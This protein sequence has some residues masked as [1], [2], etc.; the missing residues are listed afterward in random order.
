MLKLNA[1]YQ[2]K[3][4]AEQEYSSKCFHASIEVELPDGLNEDQL[5]QRI[6]STFELVKNSVESELNSKAAAV[7]IA[8]AQPTQANGNGKN[9]NLPATKKQVTYLMDLAKEK[10]VDI[11]P[12]L[13]KLNAGSAYD[14][15]REQCSQMI[16]QIR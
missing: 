12:Q 5:K 14:L 6:H 10:A 4:P 1:S 11:T 15:T 2:K 8:P 13:R 3:V 9:A 7:S 16:D